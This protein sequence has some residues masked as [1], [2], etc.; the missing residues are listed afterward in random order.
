MNEQKAFIAAILESPDDDSIRLIYADWLEEH[1]DAAR[2]EFILL[3]C[4]L[5]K[6]NS[7]SI[8]RLEFGSDS[9]KQ[10]QWQAFLR[11][12]K[13][14]SVPAMLLALI[15]E[16]ALFLRPVAGAVESGLIFG[17]R[18]VPGGPWQATSSR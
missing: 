4:E 10:M 8:H 13:L 14:D 6:L 7:P 1:G 16:L 18:W 12:T 9:S 5:G 3:Q 17:Q 15:D 2:G 11:K